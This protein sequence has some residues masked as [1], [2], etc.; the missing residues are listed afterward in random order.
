MLLELLLVTKVIVPAWIDANA[1]KPNFTGIDTFD[2]SNLDTSGYRNLAGEEQFVF[3][4]AA[5]S[6]TFTRAGGQ[7]NYF[8][9]SAHIR[10]QAQ[11]MEIESESIGYVDT[12]GCA[13]FAAELQTRF[14]HTRRI[15]L[16]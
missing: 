16:R 15:A 7:W 11:S 6:V 13:Y 3:I 1:T 10:S 4:S 9:F 14:K 8:Q 2:S 5:Q 12:S